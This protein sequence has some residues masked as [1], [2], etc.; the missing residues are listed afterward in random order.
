MVQLPV[1]G[2]KPTQIEDLRYPIL[3]PAELRRAPGGLGMAP[4]GAKTDIN[5]NNATSLENGSM[6][7]SEN[8]DIQTWDVQRVVQFVSS[9]P[10]CREYA[11]VSLLFNFLLF[12]V[13]YL[14]QFNEILNL[15]AF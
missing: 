4:V 6:G 10:T 12:P 14:F 8:K 1:M 2:I 5:V 7:G 13:I 9:V 15:L 11:E 3:N